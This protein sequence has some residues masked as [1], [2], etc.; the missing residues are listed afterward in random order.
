MC[1]NA[2]NSTYSSTMFAWNP[3]PV[4]YKRIPGHCGLDRCLQI[5]LCFHYSNYR[6]LQLR[7]VSR[8]GLLPDFPLPVCLPLL[9]PRNQRALGL[10]T[11]LN[12]SLPF[13]FARL[14]LSQRRI[15]GCWMMRASATLS[16]SRS[17]LIE[18][19][20]MA[21]S[22]RV[23]PLR[24]SNMSD[25]CPS[26]RWDYWVHLNQECPATSSPR[27]I[28]LHT[29]SVLSGQGPPGR[30]HGRNNYLDSCSVKGKN[31]S[32]HMTNQCVN[33]TWSSVNDFKQITEANFLC[34]DDCVTAQSITDF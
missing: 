24:S 15:R 12:P 23:K 17:L 21:R 20:T 31:H 1:S 7:W 27:D 9:F 29:F 22:S 3:R 18:E 30:Q 4:Q 10:P 25:R 14:S 11:R 13:P 26:L 2:L 28:L 6:N 34:R 19:C 8:D 32:S 5:H 16:N 33:A